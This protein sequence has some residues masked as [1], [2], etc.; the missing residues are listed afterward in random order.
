VVETDGSYETNPDGV[1]ETTLIRQ[2]DADGKVVR[3]DT[4]TNGDGGF[5]E[6]SVFLYDDA[7]NSIRSERRSLAQDKLLSLIEESFDSEG[8]MVLRNVDGDADGFIERVEAVV[9]DELGHRRLS[10]TYRPFD[11][12]IEV[13]EESVYGPFGIERDSRSYPLQPLSPTVQTLY[14]YERGL[15]ARVE[16][17]NGPD[18][19]YTTE[20]RYDDLGHHLSSL[21]TRAGKSSLTTY[22]HDARGFVNGWVRDDG[23]DG[24]IDGSAVC[25]ANE[26][27][28]MT[29]EHMDDDNDGTFDY[30][31]DQK[32]DEQGRLVEEVNDEDG[33][34]SNARRVVSYRYDC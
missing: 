3:I 34:N 17:S 18:L 31:F 28:V 2:F 5:D 24:T 1:A 21:H 26:D 14:T 16:H 19:V 23:L 9:Y 12:T 11:K 15:L 32:F 25:A 10:T 30:I 33:D 7:G 13:V 4:D 20:N 27:G 22:S 8:R 6:Y 29:S